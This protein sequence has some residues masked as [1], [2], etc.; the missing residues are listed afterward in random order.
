MTYNVFGGTLNPA[1]HAQHMSNYFNHLFKCIPSLFVANFTCTVNDSDC[2]LLVPFFL[3][4]AVLVWTA[5]V[6]VVD[7]LILPPLQ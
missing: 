5:F 6:H 4:T 2:M 1:Q 7:Y 3:C